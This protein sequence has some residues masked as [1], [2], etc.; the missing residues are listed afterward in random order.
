MKSSRTIAKLQLPDEYSEAFGDVFESKIKLVRTQASRL[1]PGDI[2][3]FTYAN[4]ESTRRLLVTGTNK[5]PSGK[6]LSSRS[7]YL[8]CCF[9]I[10]ESLYSIIRILS[11]LYKNR[12]KSDYQQL[13]NTLKSVLG[14]KNFKTFNMS[15]IKEPY[16]LEVSYG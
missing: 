1:L 12:I 14:I 10:Q 3:T 16:E 9:E 5:A 8:L 2:V 13:P 7:N 11:F 6:F 15:K 4:G